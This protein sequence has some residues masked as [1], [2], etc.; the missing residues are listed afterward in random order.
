[1]DHNTLLA[2]LERVSERRYNE[3]LRVLTL[4]MPDWLISLNFQM[5]FESTH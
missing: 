4:P 5:V 3:P 1:M 2:V